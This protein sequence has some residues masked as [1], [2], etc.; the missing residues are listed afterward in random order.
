MLNISSRFRTLSLLLALPLA[1]VLCA[2]TKPA[3][4]KPAAAG[5]AADADNATAL[6]KQAQNPIAS[7]ATLPFLNSTNFGVGE[8][9][10]VSNVLLIQ[11][12]IPIKLSDK[13]NFIARTII[14]VVH[15]PITTGGPPVLLPPIVP[16]GLAPTSGFVSRGASMTPRGATGTMEDSVNGLGSTQFQ[17]FF[18]PPTMKGITWG[19][20]PIIQFPTETNSILGP[21]K[22]GLGPAFVA[23][24]MPGKWVIGGLYTQT[25]DIAGDPN[26]QGINALLIQPIVNYN[27]GKGWAITTGAMGITCNFK[28][29]EGEKWNVPLGGG[30]ARIFHIGKQ[31]IKAQVVV[32]GNVVH[33][34]GAPDVTLQTQWQFLFPK[35]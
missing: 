6:A 31:A 13:L 20:G 21:G 5:A 23:L 10:R 2:Q 28:A 16:A 32:Y 8:D 29:P 35:T 1:G 14:P 33:P 30:I 25:F 19:V 12:V 4:A 34:T 24:A 22:W 7:M 15:Q 26:R 17:G 9:R 18:V 11:P 3:P 27:L